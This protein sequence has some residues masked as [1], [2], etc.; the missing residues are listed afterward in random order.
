[1][2][3]ALALG[4]R[5]AWVVANTDVGTY[6]QWSVKAGL[7]HGAIDAY[8]RRAKAWQELNER[9]EHHRTRVRPPS[10]KLDQL[11]ALADAAGV[12]RTWLATGE[13]DP[14]QG[15]EDSAYRGLKSEGLALE[16]RRAS[17]AQLAEGEV[18][19]RFAR[20][21]G[22]G[23]GETTEQ[24]ALARYF[25]HATVRAVWGSAKRRGIPHDVIQA[26][27]AHM[28]IDGEPTVDEVAT[29]VADQVALDEEANA[30]LAVKLRGPDAD[31][32]GK[33]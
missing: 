22:G 25:K 11:T 33:G 17:A 9:S 23:E 8:F 29:A 24:R 18:T 26:A 3:G 28:Q 2:K 31:D 30:A 14:R 19:M 13:G 16:L 4:D 5:L 10:M 21:D 7:S 27:V 15:D 6:P 32:V 1:M 20:P 12:R